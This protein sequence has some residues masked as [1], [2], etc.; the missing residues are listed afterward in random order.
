MKKINMAKSVQRGFT[1]IE[2]MIVVAIIGILAAV[3]LPAY[4]DYTIR[5]KAVEGLSLAAPA[6]LALAEAAARGDIS[7]ATNATVEDKITGLPVATAFSGN[8]VL[9]VLV[10]GTSAVGAD[11]QTADITITYKPAAANVPAALAGK[12]VV[13]S[14]TFDEGSSEWTIDFAKSDLDDKYLP[15]I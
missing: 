10:A 11:P 4:Q 9:S 1:L 12:K 13:L 7:T 14:G 3:A 15:K 5:A 8:V 2:L 6:K